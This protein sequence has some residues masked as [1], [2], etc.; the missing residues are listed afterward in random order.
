MAGEGG[1][2]SPDGLIFPSENLLGNIRP[3]RFNSLPCESFVFH[4]Q[5][6]VFLPGVLVS[7]SA[8]VIPEITFQPITIIG[9]KG[10]LISPLKLPM[11][12]AF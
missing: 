9:F 3:F 2:W 11:D 8:V 5:P 1:L 12:L 7:G 4:R 10:F 6:D